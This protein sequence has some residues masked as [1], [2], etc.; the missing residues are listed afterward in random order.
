MWLV[1]SCGWFL[2]T[3]EAPTPRH[4]QRR[5]S[6]RGFCGKNSFFSL[7][8]QAVILCVHLWMCMKKHCGRYIRGCKAALLTKALWST[9]GM[10]EHD[11][12]VQMGH[13]NTGWVK[14]CS[15]VLLQVL[16]NISPTD[17]GSSP[18]LFFSLVCLKRIGD[19][20]LWATQMFFEPDVGSIDVQN[21][22]PAAKKTN[23]NRVLL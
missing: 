2:L 13:T 5:A 6:R 12:E 23:K 22:G 19:A 21:V 17:P 4:V 1:V 3:S 9:L 14:F 8:P 7:C 16:L 20:S 10:K 15:Q 11:P 18:V